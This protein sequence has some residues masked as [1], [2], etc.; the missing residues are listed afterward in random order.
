MRLLAA[1]G[2]RKCARSAVLPA[3]AIEEKVLSER[4][5]FFGFHDQ[6]TGLGIDPGDLIR[7]VYSK[8]TE[9][10]V[11]FNK[12]PAG[13]A[14]FGRITFDVLETMP[15][16]FSIPD[17]KNDQVNIPF[18]FF[19]FVFFKGY[20]PVAVRNGDGRFDPRPC[21]TRKMFHRPDIPLLI[22]GY[23]GITGIT[24]IRRAP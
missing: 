3:F 13:N 19:A 15:D 14:A 9:I 22:A 1:C 16:D 23:R 20:P 17:R 21:Q 2:D 6:L 5:S 7:L 4:G 10:G 11:P 24:E 12:T 18:V 8:P